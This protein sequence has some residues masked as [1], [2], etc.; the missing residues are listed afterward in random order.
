MKNKHSVV[1]ANDV[2]FDE[3]VESLVIAE[4]KVRDEDNA[5]AQVILRQTN[6]HWIAYARYTFGGFVNGFS[7][8]LDS[9]TNDDINSIKDN[10]A[11]KM[12][13]DKVIEIA[14]S[15]LWEIYAT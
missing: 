9:V 10:P 2:D 6:N 4:F 1:N 3:C 11:I 15:D 5:P 8:C 13:S 7:M 12:M 14:N